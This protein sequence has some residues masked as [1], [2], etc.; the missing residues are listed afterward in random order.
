MS[1]PHF[2]SKKPALSD[3]QEIASRTGGT[4]SAIASHF[5]VIRKTV[6]VWCNDDPDFQAII[7][8]ERGKILDECIY[9]S[10]I[11]SRGIP[12]KDEKGAIIG[13]TERPDS[14]MVKYL[15]ST[16]GRKEGF[17][18]AIDIKAEM[19]VKGSVSIDNWLDVRTVQKKS[20]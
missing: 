12:I 10:R 15:M 1:E 8:D 5:G 20:E 7:D 19:E 17:G 4:I 3:F 11:L 16:L 18:E 9:T 2:N 6:Y 13:W 14:G